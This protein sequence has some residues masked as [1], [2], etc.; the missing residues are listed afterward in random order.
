M[1]FSKTLQNRIT[2]F[3]RKAAELRTHALSIKD[4][5][6]KEKF[7]QADTSYSEVVNNTLLQ[8]TLTMYLALS[9]ESE[10]KTSKF[11][12]GHLSDFDL[13]VN[14]KNDTAL[15]QLI[16]ANNIEIDSQQFLLL[17]KSRNCLLAFMRGTKR[18]LVLYMQ[19]DESPVEKKNPAKKSKADVQVAIEK[20]A[21]DLKK[22]AT[23]RKADETMNVFVTLNDDL[24]LEDDEEEE[25]NDEEKDDEEDEEA[26]TDIT[27]GE[28]KKTRRGMKGLKVLLLDAFP[29]LKS[30]GVFIKMDDD[31]DI[32]F[33]DSF[34]VLPE[35]LVMFEL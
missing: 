21:G 18:N 6:I 29:T 26:L 24:D 10:V 3:G 23:K 11:S 7:I 31:G 35:D 12:C 32:L 8:D 13:F 34:V 4:L 16:K 33:K 2:T 17:S 15:H 28:K 25:D 30:T 5:L 9:L 19:L 1:Q 22:L 14:G 20:N 27:G